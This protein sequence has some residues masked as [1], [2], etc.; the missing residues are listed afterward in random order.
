MGDGF[1]SPNHP[2]FIFKEKKNQ[3][4]QIYIYFDLKNQKRVMGTVVCPPPIIFHILVLF[5]RYVLFANC[6]HHSCLLFLF[7]F[8]KNIYLLCE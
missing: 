2:F 5:N 8:W 7:L 1:S 3:K 6:N 4:G